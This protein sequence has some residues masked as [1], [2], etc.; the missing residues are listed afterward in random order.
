MTTKVRR[1]TPGDRHFA[2][3]AVTSATTPPISVFIDDDGLI[4][5]MDDGQ[6]TVTPRS[7]T[8]RSGIGACSMRQDIEARVS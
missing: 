1:R 7:R 6:H 5:R 8:A 3:Q 4:G 2:D